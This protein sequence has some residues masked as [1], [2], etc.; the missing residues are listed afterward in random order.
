MNVRMLRA[1]M[2]SLFCCA[3]TVAEPP[4]TQPSTPVVGSIAPDF[5]LSTLDDKPVSL[6]ST[7]KDGP[8]VVIVL[9]GWP[10]YQCPICTKQVG[11]LIVRAREFADE[12]ARIILIYPGPAEHLKAHAAEFTADKSLPDNFVFVIDPDYVFTSAWNV[13]WDANGETA[14]PSSFVIDRGGIVRFAKVSKS[15]G[16]RSSP[17]ELIDA[18][19]ASQ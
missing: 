6:S 3:L 12:H 18:L 8:A 5:T 15:H 9:R 14:Y 7:L 13:R 17:G 10:G 16:G 1:A 19:R 11:D 2:M 4:A